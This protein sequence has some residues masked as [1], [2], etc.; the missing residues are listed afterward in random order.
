MMRNS[1]DVL[2]LILGWNNNGDLLH[3]TAF[4]VSYDALLAVPDKLLSVIGHGAD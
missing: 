2:C 3:V 4:T 1:D